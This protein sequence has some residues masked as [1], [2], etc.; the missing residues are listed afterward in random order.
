MSISRVHSDKSRSLHQLLYPWLT[1][2]VD[3]IRAGLAVN[4]I[5]FRIR[6]FSSPPPCRSRY[7]PG[8]VLPAKRLFPS[9]SARV[10]S[11]SRRCKQQLGAPG[12]DDLCQCT[13]CLCD[14]R[15]ARQY[16]PRYSRHDL[17]TFLQ[18]QHT[19]L[20]FIRAASCLNF[21]L[22][23]SRQRR[24]KATRLQRLPPAETW[25]L[26]LEPCWLFRAMAEL[27]DLVSSRTGISMRLR[28]TSAA[29]DP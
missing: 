17:S 4:A 3:R 5:P 21:V 16:S 27:Q 9:V 22:G 15:T 28:A 10:P 6:P 2:R 8:F 26:E 12:A 25:P 29:G 11:F 18:L 19:V 14:G 24:A 13:G 20:Q 7:Q 23:C 1:S